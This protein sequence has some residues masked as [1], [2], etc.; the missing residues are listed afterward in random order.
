VRGRNESSVQHVWHGDVQRK[1][2]LG[3]L[4]VSVGG[5]LHAARDAV[6]ERR[7]GDAAVQLVRSVGERGGLRDGALRR[8]RMLCLLHED[9]NVVLE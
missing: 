6:L 8:R 7:C 4:L 3:Q 2:C 1:L 5:G 9:G